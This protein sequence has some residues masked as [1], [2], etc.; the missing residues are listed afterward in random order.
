MTRNGVEYDLTK[1]F[2]KVEKDGYT[3]VFSSRFNKT[4]FE[5]RADEAEAKY[6]QKIFK[7]TGVK[8]TDLFPALNKLYTD[9]EKRGYRVFKTE[10]GVK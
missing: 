7:S 4:R 2:Y 9:I 10:I 1:S 8:P 5:C 3:F 6:T